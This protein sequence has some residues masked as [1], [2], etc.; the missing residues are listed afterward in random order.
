M[1]STG[2][3][4]AALAR[5]LSDSF[6]MDGNHIIIVL[7]EADEGIS[8]G[9]A[10]VFYAPEQGFSRTLGGRTCLRALPRLMHQ[11]FRLNK[12]RSTCLCLN[13]HIDMKANRDESYEC[14]HSYLVLR[15]YPTKTPFCVFCQCLHPNFICAA[16]EEQMFLRNLFASPISRGCKSLTSR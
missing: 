7:D 12:E 8:P 14:G 9:Q 6:E 13:N 3:G 2:S 15:L 16:F 1:R 11:N 10:C 5:S 4:R